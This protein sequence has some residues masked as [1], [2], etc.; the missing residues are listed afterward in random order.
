MLLAALRLMDLSYT[1]AQIEQALPRINRLASTIQKLR[2]IDV[3]PDTEPA[4]TFHPL[5]PGRITAKRAVFAPSRVAPFPR[6]KNET[7]I[8][9]LPVSKLAWLLRNRRI[10]S[11]EITKIYLARLKQFSPRLNCVVTM[12]DDLALDQAARADRAI[13]TGKYR[14]PLHG[15]PWG[16]KDLFATKGIPTTW[17]AEPYQDQVFD[18]NATVVD[19]L[20]KAGAVL[21]AKL[22][23]GALAMGGLWFGGMTKTPWNEANTSSGSSAGSASATAAGLV[24]FALGTE[25]LGSIVTPCT[26]CG[27]AGLRPTYGRVPRTGAMALSWTMDKI[28]PIC[29][30]AED[31]ALVLRAIAGSDG[32]DGSVP[33][34]PVEWNPARRLSAL[35][36]GLL[37]KEFDSVSEAER[38]VYEAAL[39]ALRKAGAKLTPVELPEFDTEALLLILSSEGAA[40]FDDLTRAGGLDKL[41][42]QGPGAWPNTFRG[43]RIIPAVEYIRAQRARTLMMRR[44]EEFMAKWDVLVSPP[45]ESL[46]VTNLTGH[47]QA[48]APCGFVGGM[49]R[50]LTF[51]GRLYEEGTALRVAHA[52]EQATKW[53]AMRP[54]VS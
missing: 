42:D 54:P 31:C 34:V 6:P 47:P 23:M 11:V 45:G 22:S 9:F 35:R 5:L 28:G 38:P 19:R 24:G 36:I 49:P 12:T 10:T 20:D 25:T 14:G 1:D 26:R 30:T 27:V 15:V 16:A 37:T 41:K 51:T 3:P 29:R 32:R 7:D 13:R 4:T 50:S 46:V 52:F 18:Y 2:Q 17:G 44:F 40:A 8:A 53:H 21:V 43:S 48:V 39:E 33:D